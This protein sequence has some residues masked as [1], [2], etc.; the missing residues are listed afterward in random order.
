MSEGL[1]RLARQMRRGS[2]S[3]ACRLWEHT[4]PGLYAHARALVQGIADIDADD[5]VQQAFL[6]LLELSPRRLREIRDVRAYL[7]AIVRTRALNARRA[8]DRRRVR[9]R[10]ACADSPRSAP[11]GGGIHL[12]PLT[13]DQREVV[14]L[15]H[16]A[17]LSFSQ[18][19]QATEQ[20]RSTIAGRYRAALAL[21]RSHE[22]TSRSQPWTHAGGSS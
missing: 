20:N 14:V 1:A 22:N 6:D 15:K 17:G 11:E 13:P 16:L 10:H 2:E 5:I 4:S 7:H 21:L 3:A 18:I 8:T 19:A 12:S 9:E